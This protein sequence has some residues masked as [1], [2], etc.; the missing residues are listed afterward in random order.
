MSVSQTPN[1]ILLRNLRA[2][3]PQRPQPSISRNIEF[4]SRKKSFKQ[5]LEYSSIKKGYFETT[6]ASEQ[7]LSSTKRF[8]RV[9]KAPS[10]ASNENRNPMLRS[11]SPPEKRRFMVSPRQLN[12]GN[13]KKATLLKRKRTVRN[14]D[15]QAS[16][17]GN[18]EAFLSSKN[19]S[20]KLDFTSSQLLSFEQDKS[21]ITSILGTRNLNFLNLAKKVA[22]NF[23]EV[24]P[25]RNLKNPKTYSIDKRPTSDELQSAG[26]QKEDRNDINDSIE[27]FR[28]DQKQEKRLLLFKCLT[29]IIDDR[30]KGNKIDGLYGIKSHS[31]NLF[32]KE[33]ESKIN[34]LLIIF[35]KRTTK[36]LQS[37]FK[38]VSLSALRKKNLASSIKNL[39]L[40]LKRAECSKK[41]EIFK[42][43]KFKMIIDKRSP[44][45]HNLP[46]PRTSFK[47]FDSFSL[48][49]QASGFL[50]FQCESGYSLPPNATLNKIIDGCSILNSLLSQKT[51]PALRYLPNL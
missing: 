30:L 33:R 46:P 14:N 16:F 42:I 34:R 15:G 5:K 44:Q 41:K 40:M 1:C 2:I 28:S 37:G 7:F 17:F 3:T 31:K 38:Q 21:T 39:A 36:H 9:K 43:L 27:F 51:F 45:P 4:Y 22:Q 13:P 8:R 26:D 24:I 6:R 19:V 32:D 11:Q 47:L 20:R 49:P 48:S 12:S 25:A 35:S 18:T 50:H 10:K 23:V 29:S